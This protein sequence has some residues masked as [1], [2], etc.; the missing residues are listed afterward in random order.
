[1]SREKGLR[2][3][4][5]YAAILDRAGYDVQRFHGT[6][7][8]EKDGLGLYD[9][10]AIRPAAAIEDCPAQVRLVQVKS[11]RADGV[12]DW[13][14]EAA[15]HLSDTI[16][17]EFAVCADSEGWRV[18]LPINKAGEWTYRTVVDERD[19]D[20]AMGEGVEQWLNGGDS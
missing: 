7:H 15:Q 2:R 12:H 14:Q 6:R 8:G 9:L 17:A 16:Q 10:L 3:E 13:M 18:M 1:M 11:N 19:M 5:Q 20:C 4:R